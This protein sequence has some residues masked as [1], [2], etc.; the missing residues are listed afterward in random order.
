MSSLQNEHHELLANVAELYYKQEK[1][2]AQIARL[3]GVS[4]SSISRLLTE[5][6][7]LGIVEIQINYPVHRQRQLETLVRDRF[8][9]KA[10]HVLH[11]RTIP[12][13]QRLNQIGRLAASY[14][15]TLF[16]SELILGLS[17]GTA[18]FETVQA[19]RPFSLPE[20]QVVQFIGAIGRGNRLIDGPE[21]A[22]QVAE[23]VGA[24]YHYLHAPLIVAS[25]E[26]CQS[27]LAERAIADVLELARQANVALV[28]IGSVD[29]TVSS[30]IRAGY[31]TEAQMHDIESEGAVGDICARHFDIDGNILDLDINHRVVG[32]SPHGLRNIP[33]VIG[34]AGGPVKAP[35]ILGALRGRLINVLVTD[36]VTAQKV[37]ELDSNGR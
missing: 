1:T 36:D 28:G 18:V 12:P 21:L 14:L 9:L 25:T 37:L 33:E 11:T 15:E 7:E 19:L 4:R 20:M 17:W 30:L 29:P 16:R 22:R 5:A 24:Q 2:Q 3:I 23:T 32:I 31:L 27:F 26:A 34:V 35:A 13:E 8:G 6:R 10:V